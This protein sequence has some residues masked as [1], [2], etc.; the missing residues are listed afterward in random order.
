M[1]LSAK[2]EK[3]KGHHLFQVMALGVSVSLS[4]GYITC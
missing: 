3:T 1:R 4:S 2:A